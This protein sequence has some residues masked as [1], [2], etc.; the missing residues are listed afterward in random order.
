MS[1]V[2]YGVGIDG[3]LAQYMLAEAVHVFPLGD[4]DP[5]FA[6]PLGDAAATSYH[7]VQQ[8]RAELSPRARAAVIGVGGLG[9]Y[10]VQ[11]VKQLT[12]ASVLAVDNVPERLS[13]AQHYGADAVSTSDGDLAVAMR[14]F[15]HGSLDVVLDFVGSTQTITAALGAIGSGGAVVVAGIGGAEVVLGWERM[16]R[17]SRFEN[18]RGYTRSDLN[19]VIAMAAAGRLD[20]PQSHYTFEQVET[21]LDDVRTATVSGR[22]VV[23]PNG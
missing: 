4:L 22:A 2:G 19:D 20:V 9:G 7:A 21:A 18:T 14:E 15:G 17:N 23:L 11:Y 3:G 12:G 16:P 1:H 5:L 8:A 10:A 6:A 13:L